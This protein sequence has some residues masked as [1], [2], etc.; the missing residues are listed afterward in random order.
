MP[1]R[2]PPQQRKT[3]DPKLDIVFWMLFG[4]EQNR[5]LLLSLL[6]A[7]LSPAA[8]IEAVEVLPAQPERLGVTDKNISLDLRVRLQGGEQVD[9][10]MQSQRRPALRERALYYWARLYTGQLLRGDPYT[11]LRRCV[12]VLITNYAELTGQRFHSIFQAHDRSGHE[13]LTG[14][15]ELHLLELPKL[16]SALDRNDEPSLALWAKFLAAGADEELEKLAMEH[17]MLKQAKAALDR[18][19]A[20]D[21]ARLQAEQREMALLTFEAGM[22]AAREE[23]EHKG[24]QE[25]LKQ[26][27][28]EGRTAGTTEVLLRQLTVKFGPQPASTAERLADASPADLLRWSEQV[29]SAETLE[30]VF[31]PA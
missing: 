17:P 31:A 21:I 14:H 6:N 20:D 9:V 23:A 16:P 13:L 2:D 5:E 22:A 26:G 8:P 7:V 11:A 12:V 30:G 25:G 18:L 27:L 1:E 15:L 3:L 29:L 24:R 28:K 19:S 4:A 10:E